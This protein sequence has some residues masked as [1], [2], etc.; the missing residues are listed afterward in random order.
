MPFHEGVRKRPGMYIGR[1]GSVG[2]GYI[3]SELI[4]DFAV[5]YQAKEVRVHISREGI[6]TIS[7]PMLRFSISEFLT[8]LNGGKKS[9]NSRW[10]LISLAIIPAL[11]KKTVIKVNGRIYKCS[12]NG[13]LTPAIKEDGN[14]VVSRFEV[15]FLPD[16]K[17]LKAKLPDNILLWS[18]LQELTFVCPQLKIIYRDDKTNPFTQIVWH[19]PKGIRHLL[20]VSANK[21]IGRD[22]ETGFFFEENGIRGDV[23]WFYANSYGQPPQIY[24]FAN[25]ELNSNGGSHVAGVI[26]G[27]LKG[28]KTIVKGNASRYEL[29]VNRTINNLCFAVS[30]WCDDISYKGNT[31]SCVDFEPIKK[32]LVKLVS[33]HVQKFYVENSEQGKGMIERFR[34]HWPFH[35]LKE[36]IESGEFKK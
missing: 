30:I 5:D 34:K 24:A 28:V 4:R 25:G 18:R 16:D 12:L 14:K 13:R 27:I 1:I 36:K 21:L 8:L 20:D 3:I 6:I 11:S 29:T 9:V 17:V 19:S 23:C 26:H 32:L 10:W 22:F 31:T 2:V 15:S 7:F 35:I 33:A